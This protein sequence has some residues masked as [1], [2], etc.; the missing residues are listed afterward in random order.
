MCLTKA[1][2]G[3]SGAR[4]LQSDYYTSMMAGR[5]L[6]TT[7]DGGLCD[8]CIDAAF[9]CAF[10]KITLRHAGDRTVS[11]TLARHNDEHDR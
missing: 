6:C 3:K 8:G 7:R 9:A 5:H 1:V 11:V 4:K 10:V 2:D